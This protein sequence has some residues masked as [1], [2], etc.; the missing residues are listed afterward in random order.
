MPEAASATAANAVRHFARKR[1][2]VPHARSRYVRFG[3]PSGEADLACFNRAADVRRTLIDQAEHLMNNAEHAGH[4]GK[5]LDLLAEIRGNFP[6]LPRIHA[7]QLADYAPHPIQSYQWVARMTRMPRMSNARAE[8][9][10][11]A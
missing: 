5:P 2:R 10:S 1:R 8:M 3:W 11:R 7:G 4:A 6:Q 9:C